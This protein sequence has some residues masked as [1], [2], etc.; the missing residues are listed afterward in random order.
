MRIA[1]P[2]ST[3][4]TQ[5]YI[6]QAYVD[7]ITE[8]GME[9][10]LVAP[11]NDLKAVA[12]D[13]D[14]LILPGGID[15]EPTFY[16]ENN[17]ASFAADPDK[18]NF[19]RNLFYA[20]VAEHKP[21]FGICRGFQL[22]VREYL[23]HNPKDEEWLTYYQNIGDHSLADKLSVSR[24]QG[25]HLVKVRADV[26]GG[27]KNDYE[28]VFTNS[29]HHQ[30]VIMEDRLRPNKSRLQVVATNREGLSP[31][32]DKGLTVVEGIRIENQNTSILAVQWHPEE[33][34]DYALIQRFFGV[35]VYE[36]D[37]EEAMEI[38]L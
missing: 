25:T 38:G 18:D 14:G 21:V 24:S 9:P 17:V 5:Y 23:R 10:V 26:Y 3:S 35:E 4:K 8:A 13:C 11:T 6:N 20:F 15:I 34:R 27:K 32:V 29:M 12:S 28:L 19:E 16:G 31:K 7:Y 37:E 36:E 22:I 30:A 2:T 1:L 33:M